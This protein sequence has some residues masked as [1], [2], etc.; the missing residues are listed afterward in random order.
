MAAYNERSMNSPLRLDPMKIEPQD[1]QPQHFGYSEIDDF[2]NLDNETLGS[3][4]TLVEDD[5][6]LFITLFHII[7]ET[8][9]ARA[10]QNNIVSIS[11]C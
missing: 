3:Q 10:R 11:L 1:D 5:Q 7:M 9:D 2:E 6:N 4:T 8:I